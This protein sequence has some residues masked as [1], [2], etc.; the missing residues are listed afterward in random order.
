MVAVRGG[1]GTMGGTVLG[2]WFQA[3]SSA[4]AAPLAGGEFGC[5]AVVFATTSDRAAAP[6]R[7]ITPPSGCC[8]VTNFAKESSLT[9]PCLG[10]AA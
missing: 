7:F 9:L 6:S 2:V 8:E 5:P 10:L 1:G 4:C 3:V